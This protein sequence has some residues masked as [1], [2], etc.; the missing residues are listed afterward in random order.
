MDWRIKDKAAILQNLVNRKRIEQSYSAELL[1]NIDIER[2]IGKHMK[3]TKLPRLDATVDLIT[4]VR[5]GDIV[6]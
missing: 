3:S 4:K 5:S 2:I 1:D 6:L